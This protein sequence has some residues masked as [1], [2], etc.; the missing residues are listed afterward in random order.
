MTH[1]REPETFEKECRA[2]IA[3]GQEANRKER[4]MYLSSHEVH[5][6]FGIGP[7]AEDIK[8]AWT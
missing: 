7:F 1:K 2:V 5:L 3:R 4:G 8:E 6:L